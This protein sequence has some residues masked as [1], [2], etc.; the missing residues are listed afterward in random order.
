MGN[1]FDILIFFS[2]QVIISHL[3]VYTY[4]PVYL[5]SV[6]LYSCGTILLHRSSFLT[7][8]IIFYPLHCLIAGNR[9]LWTLKNSNSIQIPCCK[10]VVVGVLMSTS[11]FQYLCFLV[12][13]VGARSTWVVSKW[14]THAYSRNRYGLSP[15]PYISH[16]E[17]Q[18]LL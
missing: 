9:R 12:R 7:F 15:C 6:H 2:S 3:P 5:H 8:L 16:K 17:K 10:A 1:N 14:R 13:Y 11:T 4:I 18:I